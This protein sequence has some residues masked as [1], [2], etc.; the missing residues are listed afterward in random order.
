MAVNHFKVHAQMYDR[1]YNYIPSFDDLF[2]EESFYLFALLVTIVSI[3]V[4]FLLSRRIT[5]R[6]SDY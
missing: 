6:E 5:L 2:D 1:L 4:C 3:I